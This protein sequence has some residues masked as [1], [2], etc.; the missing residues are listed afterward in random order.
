MKELGQLTNNLIQNVEELET[1]SYRRLSVLAE[2]GKKT[3]KRHQMDIENLILLMHQNDWKDSLNEIEF[4]EF[5]KNM[6]DS[7][8]Q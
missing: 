1:E 5:T 2:M 6:L 3:I 4:S 8:K 7:V